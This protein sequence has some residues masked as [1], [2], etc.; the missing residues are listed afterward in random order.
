MAASRKLALEVR[1]AAGSSATFSP[2]S[3][4]GAILTQYLRSRGI[5]GD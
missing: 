1:A 4:T 5:T 3:D 2:T